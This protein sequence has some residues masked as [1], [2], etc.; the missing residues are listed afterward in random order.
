MTWKYLLKKEFRQ[1]LRDPGMPRMV[2]A[3]PLLIVLVFPF[4]A[5]MEVRNIRLAVVDNDRSSESALLIE[6][7]TNS[8]Y[9]ILE[10]ICRTP[11]EA[12]ALMDSGN[13]DATLTINSGFAEYMGG[14]APAGDPLPLGIAVNTVNGTRGSIGSKYL[15]ACISSF[16]MSQGSASREA[17]AGVSAGT[18]VSPSKVEVAYLYNPYLDYKLFMLPAL[19]V[20]AITMMCGFLPALNIV[21]E[22]E[23]GTI[24][25]INVTPVRKSS[26]IICK[27]IPYVAV[28][29]FLLFSCLLLTRIVFGYSCRGS[30][31]AIALF[32]LAHIVVMASFGLLISNYSENT[33]QAMFVIWFFSMV[34][35]LMSGIFTPIASM[36]HWAE[37]ITYANPLRYYAD[38]MRSIYLKGGTLPDNWFNLV[39]LAGIGTIT[40]TWAIKSYKKT[41]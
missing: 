23:K 41:V 39:C 10:D 4:A 12:R 19:I 29:Y 34:F 38:A 35:M 27:M 33:Q 15:T 9:F 16:I 26:F 3:F 40:T 2:M 14:G 20:I 13:I 1:F 32:T 24:E 21:G 30:L 28:A 6:K 25:Q 7:C 31:L 22:K 5:S 8:G 36:P 18:N 17:G 11:T 37:I